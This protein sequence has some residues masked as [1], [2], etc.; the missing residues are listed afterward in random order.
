MNLTYCLTQLSQNADTISSLVQ[1]VSTTQSRWKPKP[2]DWSILEVI[3]HLYDE[4]RED[5]PARLNLLLHHPG[6]PWPKF[7]PER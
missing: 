6:Q 4:E 3:N 2:G 1:N 7:D 5:F